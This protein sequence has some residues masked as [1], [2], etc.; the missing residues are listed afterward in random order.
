MI[1]RTLPERREAAG[2]VVE[3]RLWAELARERGRPWEVVA[4]GVGRAAGVAGVGRAADQRIR[5]APGRARLR[6]AEPGQERARAGQ[7]EWSRVEQ[8]VTG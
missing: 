8:R 2:R 7:R 5:E 1:P 4:A 6:V 3:G